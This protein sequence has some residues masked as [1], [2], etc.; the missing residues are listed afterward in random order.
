MVY[1][2]IKLIIIQQT[3]RPKKRRQPEVN[4]LVEW[5]SRVENELEGEN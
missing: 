3:D 2:Q 4:D 1:R 5:L